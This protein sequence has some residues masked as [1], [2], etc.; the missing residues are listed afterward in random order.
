MCVMAYASQRPCLCA[1][2]TVLGKRISKQLLLLL[3]ERVL[4]T[5]GSLK[6]AALGS[7]LSLSLLFRNISEDT[8]YMC[9]YLLC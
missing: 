5:R 2:V 4:G 1:E 9:A 6:S 3:D 8:S 7:T